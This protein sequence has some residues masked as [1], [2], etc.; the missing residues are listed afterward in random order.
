[1]SSAVSVF[2]YYLQMQ[3]IYLCKKVAH[4]GFPEWIPL[5]HS[6]IRIPFKRSTVPLYFLSGSFSMIIDHQSS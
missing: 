4:F 5:I 3:K 6:I 1:M 2:V